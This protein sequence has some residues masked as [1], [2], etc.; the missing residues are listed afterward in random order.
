[1]VVASLA[2]RSLRVRI[3][4]ERARPLRWPRPASTGIGV[5]GP[6]T[7]PKRV[8]EFHRTQDGVSAAMQIAGPVE[9]LD[10]Q[11]QQQKEPVHQHAVGM[12]MLDMLHPVKVLGVSLN[13][14]FSISQRLLA[15]LKNDRVPSLAM[16]KSVNQSAWTMVPSGLC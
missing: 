10:D 14:W 11:G 15:S 5:G 7:K 4:K 16:E 9:P 3:V 8:F 12:M 1:M 13:P 6:E 2:G